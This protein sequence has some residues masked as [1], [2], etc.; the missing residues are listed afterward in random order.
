[1][2]LH[3]PPCCCPLPTH[4]SA[5]EAK[6]ILAR[7]NP[8]KPWGVQQGHYYMRPYQR[9][10]DDSMGLVWTR[11]PVRPKRIKEKVRK[12]PQL[13]LVIRR[14]KSVWQPMDKEVEYGAFYG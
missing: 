1:M 5:Q 6:E 2:S 4:Y 13:D 3:A 10:F 11:P 7:T 8:K 12:M 9:N 14:R